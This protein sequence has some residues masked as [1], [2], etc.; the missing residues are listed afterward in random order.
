MD[1]AIATAVAA[2][3]LGRSAPCGRVPEPQHQRKKQEGTL[4]LEVIKTGTGKPDLAAADPLFLDGAG[5]SRQRQQCSRLQKEAGTSEP[6][7]SLPATLDRATFES[8]PDLTPDPEESVTRSIEAYQKF[9][10][11]LGH[12]PK[13]R[14]IV[15][16]STPRW[17]TCFTTPSSSESLPGR[18]RRETDAVLNQFK[19]YVLEDVVGKTVASK[20]ELSGLAVG[21]P[22]SWWPA[23]P[24]IHGLVRSRSSRGIEERKPYLRSLENT[25][26]LLRL[27]ET[28]PHT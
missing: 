9:L 11:G 8:S 1:N 15:P 27:P 24:V 13:G 16:A 18:N 20:A 26:D 7:P 5:S 22:T 6:V 19:E 23:R 17:T 25:S 2:G 4:I 3:L 28:L 12:K 10:T 21:L 14:P